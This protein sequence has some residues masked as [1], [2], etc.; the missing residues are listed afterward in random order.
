M[1]FSATASFSAAAVTAVIGVASLRKVSVGRQIPLACIPLVFGVQ[2]AIEG[3]HW[4]LLGRWP[5]DTAV[6][7]LLTNA[8]VALA[9]VVWPLLMPVAVGLVE[10]LPSR[11]RV[12]FAL[13]A[14]GLPAAIYMSVDAADHPFTCTIVQ[15]S[16]SYTN[17]RPF[18]LLVVAAYFASVGTP[19]LISSQRALRAFGVIATIGLA[20]SALVRWYSFVSVWCF[21]STLA[22]AFVYLQLAQD[23]E[24]RNA[25]TR[26]LQS[27][28]SGAAIVRRLRA[29]LG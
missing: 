19:L 16:L 24:H 18:P 28:G 23:A 5:Q 17:Y 12:I 13:L 2:Q 15:N 20:I 9:L 26:I 10:P 3:A 25:A 29:W 7:F 14:A 27:V 22:S 1:C 8:F 21:F 4:L 11:R 6:I